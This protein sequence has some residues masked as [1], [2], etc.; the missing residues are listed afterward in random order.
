MASL[1][2]A[3]LSTPLVVSV[4]SI[5]SLDFA[6]AQ[7]PGWQVTVFPP[8]FV[9][10]AVFAGFAMV[11]L[12]MIPVRTFYGFQNYI[13]I[14]HLDVMAKV[15]LAT[16]MLVVYG[17][18]MEAFAS[19]YSSSKYEQYLLYNRLQG[20]S[21]W[22]YYG[23]L[24]CNAVAIQPLWFKRVRQNIPALLIISA[25]VSVGM[26]L[27]RYV[28]IVLS[29]QREFLPS[30]WDMYVPTI[31]DWSLYLGTFGLFFTLTFLFIRVLPMI[32]IFEIRM[33]LHQETE[34]AHRREAA[35][36]AHGHDHEHAPSPASAD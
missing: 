26:W 4:H 24:F 25:I 28:I 33:F 7:V 22:A 23:L 1:L 3:G 20:P 30:S 12:L 18:F 29:L 17:Y 8:Y 27:E 6:V 5:I 15:M 16:G 35:A 19:L 34:R 2:L 10:G 13:T 11:L 31:W 21:A 32:N 9:A 36:H 14:K